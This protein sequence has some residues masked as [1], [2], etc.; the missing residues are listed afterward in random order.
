MRALQDVVTAVC[1]MPIDFH[2]RRDISMADLIWEIEYP[3]F[4]TEITEDVLEEHV[5]AHPDLLGV[6]V[7]YS[8]DQRCS[9]AWMLGGRDSVGDPT[10]EWHVSYW[11]EDPAKRSDRVFDDQFGACAYFI[12]RQA[13]SFAA[14]PFGSGFRRARRTRRRQ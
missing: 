9:P 12:K 8:E 1:R 4:A 14:N 13:D 11:H 6:W 2:E 10:R 7:Q 5:R 3:R